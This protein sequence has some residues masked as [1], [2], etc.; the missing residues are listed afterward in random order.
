M[1][2]ILSRS[3]YI[4][5]VKLASGVPVQIPKFLLSKISQFNVLLLFLFSVFFSFTRFLCIFLTFLKGCIHFFQL[6]VCVF[7]DFFKGL[8]HVLRSFSHV[9]A[10]LEFSGPSHEE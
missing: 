8:I 4:L 6:I 10:M 1:P 9:S 7:M 5:L 2:R 3:S